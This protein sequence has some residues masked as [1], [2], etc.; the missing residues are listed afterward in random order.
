[1]PREILLSEEYP[2]PCE[3]VWQLLTDSAELERWLMP[4]DFVPEA[5]RSFTMTTK[6]APGFDG[7]VRCKVLEIEPPRRMRWSWGSGRMASTVTFELAPTAKGTRLTLRHEGFKGLASILP[8][9][10]LRRGW[11]K[12]LQVKIAG[13]LAG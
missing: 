4:N 10:L 13:L 6:P 8:F 5:G 12:K 9:V 11:R 2:H 1:V 7:I 3:R